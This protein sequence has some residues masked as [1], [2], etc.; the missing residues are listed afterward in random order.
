MTTTNSHQPEQQSST[1]TFVPA[2]FTSA[3]ATP[4]DIATVTVDGAR[5]SYRTYG[6]QDQPGIILVHGGSAHA[7]WWD[8]IAPLLASDRR[9]AAIDLSGHGDSDWRRNYSLDL[10]ADEVMA[11]A[12][13]AGID[14]PPVIVGHS[15]GGFVTWTAAE[16]Y[17]SSLAGAITI[18]SPVHDLTPEQIAARERRAFGPANVYPSQEAAMARFRP[19]P[20]QDT[21]LPYVREHLAR[22]SVRRSAA[23]WSWKFDRRIFT[24]PRM[25]RTVLKPFMCRTTLVRSSNG[26]VPTSMGSM[27]RD[28]LHAAPVIEIPDAGHHVMLDQ[29][30]C[31]VTALRATLAGWNA[32]T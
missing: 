29:P 3:L 14:G 6:P 31:L 21:V 16:R 27:I 8:H 23:G 17:G 19:V 32:P 20:A 12:A 18:D 9:V 15:M 13:D 30:L 26:L 4:V 5:I 28:R 10:W 22:T 2:W 25:S 1:A 24:S 7:R 11:V